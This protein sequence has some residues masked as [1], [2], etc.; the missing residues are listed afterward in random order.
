M[1]RTFFRIIFD[2]IKQKNENAGRFFEIISKKNE[3]N[4]EKVLYFLELS[5]QKSNRKNISF[6]QKTNKKV[7][8]LKNINLIKFIIQVDSY[9]NI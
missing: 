2:K 1:K 6:S 5:S 8:K 3:Q 7:K 4:N 9:M